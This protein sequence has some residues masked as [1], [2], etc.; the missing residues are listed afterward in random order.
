M[1]A[2][3]FISEDSGNNIFVD[4]KVTFLAERVRPVR[5]IIKKFIFLFFYHKNIFNYCKPN[6]HFTCLSIW[7]FWHYARQC[8]KGYS[9]HIKKLLSVN[10]QNK[11]KLNS[12]TYPNQREAHTYHF[13]PYNFPSPEKNNFFD[14]KTSPMLCP[15]IH[16]QMFVA[17]M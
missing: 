15:S 9:S 2:W 3:N 11:K 7:T 17:W 14:K 12:E 4:K 13:L 1:P 5:W 16:V 6:R 8:K 10:F